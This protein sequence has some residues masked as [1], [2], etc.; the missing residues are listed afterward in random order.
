VY[1]TRSLIIVLVHIWEEDRGS[2][3]VKVLCYKSEGR[4]FDH[5]WCPWIFHW[6]N[7]CTYLFIHTTEM[8]H[9]RMAL[10]S[11]QKWVPGEF[12]EGEGGRCVRLTTYQ[13]SV[14]LSRNLGALTF[15]NPLGT[16]RPVMG[17]IFFIFFTYLRHYSLSCCLVVCVNIY[18]KLC[19][20]NSFPQCVC[21]G[22]QTTRLTTCW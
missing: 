6:L 13:H 8:A 11:T 16:S 2:T 1:R 9:F 17:L 12:P 14:P 5:S 10:G 22:G 3:V 19:N 18:I 21:R 15:W 7:T 20:A 4:W